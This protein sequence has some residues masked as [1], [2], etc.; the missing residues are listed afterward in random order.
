MTTAFFRMM[1]LLKDILTLKSLFSAFQRVKEN[2]G[3]A[4]VDGVTIEEFESDLEENLIKLRNEILDQTYHPLPLLKILV[5]KGNGEARPLL[6][7]TIK[8]R[9]AQ[10]ATL[11][12]IEPIFES[13]FEHCS[14]AYRK[15][16]SVKQAVYQIK[17]YHEKGYTWVVDADI[18]AYFDSIDHDLLFGKVKGIVKDPV[19]LRL[20]EM[21][22]KAE[23][24]DGEAMTQLAKGIP[25]GSVI[26]PMLAN[27]F[28]D[29][30]DEEL[31]NQ[32]LKLVRFA[33]DFIILCKTPEKAKEALEITDKILDKLSLELDE[34]DIVSFDQGFKYLGVYFV[35]SMI[36]TPYDKPKR[37]RRVL[38][39]PPPLDL[40]SYLSRKSRQG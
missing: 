29:Q 4:G 16:R 33:D 2:R 6:I 25:Q 35:R 12:V 20:I 17:E 40:S 10:S 27:L 19:V 24:W 26:S 7:P 11:E 14:F 37:E 9:V 34:A 22:V 15:G 21:W 38:Y 1:P 39:F 23:V 36:F 18:D 32:G 28:L 3:C 13:E 5:D 31:L 8:D 30:L